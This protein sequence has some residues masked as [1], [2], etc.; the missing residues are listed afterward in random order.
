MKSI[1]IYLKKI[2]MISFTLLSLNCT[3]QKIEL[4]SA[5]SQ[6][7]EFLIEQATNL[8]EK[9]SDTIAV[10]QANYFL[11]LAYNVKK[12]NT[13]I[14]DLYIKSLF[15]QGMFLEEDNNIKDSLFLKGSEVAKNS[16][17]NNNIFKKLVQNSSIGDSTFKILSALSEAPKDLVTSMYW[18]ATNKLWYLNTKPAIERINERELLEVIMHRVISLEP[19]YDYGGAY[20]FFGVFYSRIPGVELSQS[21]TYFEKAISSNEAYLGNKVQMSEFY[22]QKSEDKT[23][24]IKQLELV[25]SL[26]ASMN[27][28]SMAENL[29]YQKRADKLL[30][31]QYTLFE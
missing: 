5:Q 17:L 2:A 3:S 19:N 6:N 28:N 31:Q 30:L 11:G 26:D 18:W 4:E 15:F 29:Y 16:V 14:T 24:F 7:I 10:K 25:K 13:Q 9:R 27:N 1:S 21:K 8:W 12:T 22:Y 23:S 20:R